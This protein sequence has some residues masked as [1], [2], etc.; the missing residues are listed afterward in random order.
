MGD[1]EPFFEMRQIP[2]ATT[3]TKLEHFV[4]CAENDGCDVHEM[5][6]MIDGKIHS[7]FC[8]FD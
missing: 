2:T 7:T 1:A 4:E 5:M 6:E 3:S 8:C